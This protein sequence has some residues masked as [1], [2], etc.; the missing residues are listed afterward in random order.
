MMKAVLTWLVMGLGWSG[1]IRAAER[2]NV[3]WIVSEDNSMHYLRHFFPGG[4]PAPA[5]EA[6]AAQG[7]TFEHAFSNAPVCSVARTTLATG[8]Y[9]PRVGTQ[10]HRRYQE[11]AMPKGLRMFPAYL[12]DA[13]YH[14]TNNAKK[15]YNA[16]EGQGVWDA[17]SDRASWRDRPDR[18]QPFF[19]MESH[20][21]SHESGLQFNEGVYQGERPA[22]DPAAVMLAPYHPD[23]PLFRYTQARYLDKMRQIDR[24]VAETVAKLEEDGLLESTFVFYFGDHGGVLP[25]GK[26]YIYDTGLHVPLVVRVPEKFRHL[27]AGLELGSRVGGFVSF[28]DFGPTVL[29]LA[30]V[31]VPEGV[32]GR[33]FLGGNV[34]REELNARDEVLGYAD[35]MDEKYDMVRA[36]RKGKYHYMR[37][38][39][40]WL[41]DG[42]Q[43]N[44]RY[45]SLAY[46]EWRSLNQQ[47][48]LEGASKA[49]FEP[50]PVEMLF[51]CEADPHNARNLAGDP[52]HA[53]TLAAMRQRLGEKLRGLPDLSFYPESHLA[54]V[55]MG[56]PVAFGKAHASEIRKLADTADLA[57][58]GF[59]EAR[60][61]LEAAL[62]DPNQWVRYWAAMACTA[63]GEPAA[64]LAPA[65]EALLQDPEPAVRLRAVEFLGRIGKI[66]PQP[67]LAALVNSTQDAIFATEVLN[68]VVWFRDHFG[69]AYPAARADFNPR[70]HG[71][72]VDRRL[73][74]L[75]GDPYPE[76]KEPGKKKKGK[77]GKA[78]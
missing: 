73:D 5:I 40:P 22:H 21:E 39:Q 7:L 18:E 57:L 29:N 6:L 10:F 16:A 32:D 26:G 23:T 37:C 3:V 42:L 66:N 72:D 35:R 77:K 11:A 15:D 65:V 17:S 59:A 67:A 36:L 62:A 12:R 27:A 55:A 54:Q 9:G 51:D 33:P 52:A 13:G 50:R 4:A 64:G 43:N 75:N 68:S 45:R 2:P 47:G 38:F 56:D 25:R 78:K 30:G 24:I 69:G 61:K 53:V 63:P 20:A 49:F 74:Y 31:A 14:T 76:D 19:H 58:E 44:Y 34:D 8:C 46:A 70:T 48:R 28:I 1:M 60:P 71:A 41:P